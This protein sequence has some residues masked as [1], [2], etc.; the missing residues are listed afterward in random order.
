[1]IKVGLTLSI[2]AFWRIEPLETR[3]KNMADNKKSG[4]LPTVLTYNA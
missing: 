4:S 1:V 3:E 2:M